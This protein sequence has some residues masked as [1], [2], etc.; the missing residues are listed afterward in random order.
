MPSPLRMNVS[1][2]SST[3]GTAAPAGTRRE[4]APVAAWAFLLLATTLLAVACSGRTYEAGIPAPPTDC[5]N[6]VTKYE[7]CV[8]IA[9]PSLPGV[10]KERAAQTR[11][12][13]EEE[14]RRA[15]TASTTAAITAN[16]TALATK[17][18]DNLQRLNASCGSTRTN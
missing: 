12:A 14:A 16:L 5:D 6:F 13:L 18:H 7:S 4:V 2:H 1:S 10:A 17:C 9:V 3:L 8:Q 15:N 11:G